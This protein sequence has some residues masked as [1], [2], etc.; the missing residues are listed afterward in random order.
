MSF[1]RAVGYC[2][3]NYAK[4][5]GRGGRSEYWWF[6]LA[7]FLGE[8]V[9]GFIDNSTGY[10]VLA[11]LFSLATIIP[12]V[13]AA[14]RRLHDTDRSGY[15]QLIGILPLIGWVW[16]VVLLV[17]PSQPGPNRFGVSAAA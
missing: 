2:F 10:P 13:A 17:L 5:G 7:T 16:L 9:L 11:T 15:W 8:L 1:T 3:S 12:T 14:A 4:F 6:I